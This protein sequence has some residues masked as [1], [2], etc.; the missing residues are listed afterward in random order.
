MLYN[1]AQIGG[2]RFNQANGEALANTKVLDGMNDIQQKIAGGTCA[3]GEQGYLE[4]RYTIN[5]L[6]GSMTIPLVQILIH[7]IQQQPRDGGANFIELYA[8]SFLPR[9]EACNPDVYKKLL[10]LLVR[11]T[12]KEADKATA[13]GLLQSV[14]DC[15][16]VTCEDIGSY[17]S[18]E[19]PTCSDDEVQVEA[20]AGYSPTTDVHPVSMLEKWRGLFA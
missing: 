10:E 15:V 13:I 6:F 17:E 5:K 16:D 20:L 7:H 11:N 1:L 4:M 18:G 3:G 14:Y 12:L 19:V 8:L 9:V 2:Q